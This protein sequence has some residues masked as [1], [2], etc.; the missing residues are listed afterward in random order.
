[1]DEPNKPKRKYRKRKQYRRS[2]FRSKE[3]RAEAARK[4][5]DESTSDLSYIT[6]SPDLLRAH[7][8]YIAKSKSLPI[9]KSLPTLSGPNKGL[10]AKTFSSFSTHYPFIYERWVH[11]IK[12][13]NDQTHPMFK[14]FG[15]K[16]VTLSKEFLDGKKFCMWCLH[17]G[18]TQS[19]FEYRQYL[20]RKRKNGPYS[21]HNCF[22]ISEKEIHECKSLY[23]VL[24][25]LRLIKLYEESH[26]K[27]VSY[28][29]YYT[30]YYM[31][32]MSEED[33]RSWEYDPRNPETTVGFKP[34]SFYA[35][36]AKEG[37]CSVTTFMSRIHYSYLNGGF[38]I[39]PY[40]M[41]KPEYSVKEEANKQGKL[42]YKQQYD[43]NRQENKNNVYSN[44]QAVEEYSNYENYNVYNY[45]QDSDVYS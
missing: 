31:Y 8:R 25:S 37:D 22:V 26:D 28:M 41:L 6:N 2:K 32:D 19:T 20:Q 23:L 34:T 16:G 3:E 1:M 45:K 18:L 43:R 27:S 38:E 24:G 14:F 11:L 29:T 12:V 44:T 10:V 17:H 5:F 7:A 15:G 40:D 13:C 30:R 36:V 33:A 21:R 42:S 9:F 4:I 39:R 35:S